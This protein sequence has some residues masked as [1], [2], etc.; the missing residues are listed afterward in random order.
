MTFKIQGPSLSQRLPRY[1]FLSR[2]IFI[3]IIYFA[4]FFLNSHTNCI[5]FRLHK[6]W[7]LLSLPP[8][9]MALF[10]LL[11]SQGFCDIIF[12]PFWVFKNLIRLKRKR[13]V[14]LVH[15]T[16][17]DLGLQSIDF[18]SGLKT[19]LCGPR[20]LSPGHRLPG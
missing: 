6:I 7:S 10:I 4:L 14:I 8:W 20:G 17:L 1:L 12:I 2:Y 9:I 5:S 16:L 19:R 11:S 18:W 3:F 15:L 13:N